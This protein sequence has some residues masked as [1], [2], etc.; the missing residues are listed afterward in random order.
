MADKIEIEKVELEP[1]PEAPAEP[2][3]PE[4]GFVD[5]YGETYV[6][7]H[8]EDGNYVGWYKLPSK[9]ALAER[10]GD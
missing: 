1:E 7:A 3:V 10:D 6:H 8:D 4:H 2:F 9:E 5:Q